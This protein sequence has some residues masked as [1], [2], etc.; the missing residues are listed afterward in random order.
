MDLFAA[1]RPDHT[2]PEQLNDEEL[3]RA[4]D[5]LGRKLRS[6]RAAL[7]T[8]RLAWVA[9]LA[10]IL[11]VGFTL[12]WVGPAPFLS[13]IFANDDTVTF[14]GLL[15]WWAVVIAAAL[16]VGIV[17]YRVYA[18]RLHIVRGW[19]NKAHDVERRLQHAEAEAK[20]RAVK[21]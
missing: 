15:V 20:R 8:A 21:S 3:A 10:A 5:S 9:V 11:A 13:R 14:Q 12:L 7:R 17:S 6:V 4:I 19:T 2:P 18:H 1:P 16:F